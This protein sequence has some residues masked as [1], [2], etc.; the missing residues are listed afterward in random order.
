VSIKKILFLHHG[1]YRNRG[2]EK[3][4]LSLLES[5]DRKHF[6]PILICNH[7]PFAAD[8]ENKGIKTLQITWPEVMIETG[9]KRLQFIGILK[10][11]FWLRSLI[12]KE[13]ITLVVC[14]SGVT[15]QSGYYA[16]K[17]CG[18][19]SI[20][21]LHALYTKRYIYLYRL[22]KTNLAIFV[23]NAIK[24]AMNDKVAFNN[25]LLIH[26]GIDTEHF[27]PIENPNKNIIN[28]LQIDDTKLII[29]QV[30]CLIYG[31]GIDLLIDAANILAKK[32]IE[33]QIVL[34]GSGPDEKEFKEM[35][36]RDNL[37]GYITF[38]G[39]TDSP[40]LF[41]KH[42]FDINVLAS[43]VEAFGITLAEGAACGLP[44]VG[45]NTNGIPEIICDSESGLLFVP[46]NAT[47][48]AGKLEILINDPALRKQM[49]QKGRQHVIENLSKTRQADKF[50]HALLNLGNSNA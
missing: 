14:N 43:R 19:P 32:S 27:K 3:V 35:V 10:T 21:Y 47:D 7:E 1:A 15:T 40:E 48:L 30:G 42:V 22:H 34:V 2:S 37:D 41:Y 39:E 11:V 20:S 44:C 16:A 13:S 33:F 17:L 36:T 8:A 28:G 6:E 46:G 38:A 49:G 50:N 31:K 18:I 12:K 5:L 45:A 9:H 25:R 24:T 29:G 23:S 4:L 26:N